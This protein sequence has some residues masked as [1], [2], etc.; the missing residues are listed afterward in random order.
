MDKLK[1]YH[2]ISFVGFSVALMSLIIYVEFIK[3]MFAIVGVL[4]ISI[5]FSAVIDGYIND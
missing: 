2:V 5:V 3:M 1:W 4:A